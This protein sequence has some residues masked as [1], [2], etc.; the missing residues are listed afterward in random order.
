MAFRVRPPRQW[1][2]ARAQLRQYGRTETW[3]H[4]QAVCHSARGKAGV[5]PYAGFLFP[6]SPTPVI[7]RAQATARIIEGEFHRSRIPCR[8]GARANAEMAGVTIMTLH[9]SKGLE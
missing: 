6:C 7:V 3:R 2:P 4:R 9:Q 1:L 5:L 8:R